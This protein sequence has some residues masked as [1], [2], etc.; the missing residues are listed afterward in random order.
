MWGRGGGNTP[1]G[2]LIR[3]A[4]R[5][6]SRAVSTRRRSKGGVQ[7]PRCHPILDSTETLKSLA[8][9]GIVWGFLI[10]WFRRFEAVLKGDLHLNHDNDGLLTSILGSG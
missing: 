3:A 6:Q 7:L 4:L 10:N 8:L 9:D 1:E 2:G 5:H